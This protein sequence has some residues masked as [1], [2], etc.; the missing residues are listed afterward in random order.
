MIG[1]VS[2]INSLLNGRCSQIGVAKSS[3]ML[4]TRDKPQIKVAKKKIGKIYKANC[5]K[6]EI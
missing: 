2:G 3:Y 1:N 4:L 5:F 6:N